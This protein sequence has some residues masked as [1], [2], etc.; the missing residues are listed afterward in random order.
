VK[1]DQETL[2][3]LAKKR[4]YKLRGVLRSFDRVNNS[5]AK[6]ILTKGKGTEK[7]FY[8]FT[9]FG[10]NTEAISRL[11]M[12]YRMKVWFSVRCNQHKENWYTNLIIESF[13]HWSV[14]EDKVKKATRI[15]ELEESQVR[16]EFNQKSKHF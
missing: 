2:E 5:I 15:K 14:A 6:I 10:Q 1:P 4:Q 16:M 3:K 11:K 9:S 13:E 8:V 12:G 7:K